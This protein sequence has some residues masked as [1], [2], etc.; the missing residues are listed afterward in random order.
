[1][2]KR[3]INAAGVLFCSQNTQ[4]H[5]FLLRNDRNY[6]SWSLPGGKVEFGE[7][8]L[9]T[10]ERECGEEIGYW[11]ER[12]KLFP[13]EQF[14]SDDGN[15]V[16]HTFYCLIPD[17]FVPTLNHEHIGFAWVDNKTYP[18]PLHQGLFNTLNYDL[19]RQKIDII[20]NAIK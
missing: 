16:Y 11:P 12:V 15:F 8:L 7:T 13:I 2:G 20:Q 17:E 19:I 3:K 5:L 6:H 10:L 18:R 4:R 14:N 1:M 9:E